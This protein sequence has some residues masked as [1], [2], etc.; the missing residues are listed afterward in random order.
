MT[1]KVSKQNLRPAPIY[2]GFRTRPVK[3]LTLPIVLDGR[4]HIDYVPTQV[5]T[6]FLRYAFPEPLDGMVF[7]SAQSDGRNVV[8]FDGPGI[9]AAPDGV[10]TGTRLVLTPGSIE[11]YRVTTVIRPTTNP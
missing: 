10:G 11:K 1:W 4:E 2:T 9:S 8:L 7:P 5:F 6:E 3:E